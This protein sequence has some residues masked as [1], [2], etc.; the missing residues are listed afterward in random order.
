MT[1]KL[2]GGRKNAPRRARAMR[3]KPA[4]VNATTA[5]N[6]SLY[7]TPHREDAGQASLQRAPNADRITLPCRCDPTPSDRVNYNHAPRYCEY[8]RRA[9]VSSDDVVFGR[10]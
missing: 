9:G 1:G 6:S 10:Q 5:E 8:Q 2:N 3:A 7:I 4:W